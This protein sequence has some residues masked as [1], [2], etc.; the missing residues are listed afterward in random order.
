VNWVKASFDSVRGKIVSEWKRDDKKFTLDVTI[1]PNTTATVYVP[2]KSAD[3][4]T[5]SGNPAAQSPGVKFLREE[6]GC[7][8][9][10]I[11]SGKYEFV[12]ALNR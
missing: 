3:A 6:N 1:P 5:E 7:A 10:E 12:S 4:V 9:F 11:G 8:V 2:A